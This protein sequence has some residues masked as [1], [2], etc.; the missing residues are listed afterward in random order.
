MKI[1]RLSLLTLSLVGFFG[2]TVNEAEARILGRR[3]NR[4]TPLKHY[5][6]TSK[7]C[8]GPTVSLLAEDSLAGWTSPG[9]GKPGSGWSVVDGILHLQG[10]GGD[11]VTDRQY[12]NFV[13]DF[14]WTHSK[15][16]N[17]GIKYRYQKFD[18]K[19][20]LG[21]EYQ[22]LDDFGT[23]EGM[24]PK[25]NTATLYDILPTNSSKSLN[26]RDQINKGRIVVNG[27]RIE[28][29]LNG[30][31]VMSVVVGSEEWKEA[32]AASKFKGIDGF[33]ENNLGFIMVQDHQSEVWFHKITIREILPSKNVRSCVP[34][35]TMFRK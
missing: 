16:G 35:R 9:G 8:Y 12:E 6:S 29:W 17:S 32:V 10:K 5:V 34:C 30:R 15:A 14:E 28:H 26:H 3:A 2:L 24:K 31:K 27:D 20:W 25:N 7:T 23:P 1:L 11:I 18:G 13:L 22:V 21:L 33:G 4:C 19:G